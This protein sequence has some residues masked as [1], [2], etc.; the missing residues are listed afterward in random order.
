MDI[1][2]ANLHENIDEAALGKLFE[3]F[4]TVINAVVV[5]DRETGIS[6]G[7]GFVNMQNAIEAQRAID[8]MHGRSVAGKPLTV[9]EANTGN[10]KPEQKK[11][12][13]V[14][15]K[16]TRD[17]SPVISEVDGESYSDDDEPRKKE[18]HKSNYEEK[19]HK[20]TDPSKYEKNL[21]DGYVRISFKK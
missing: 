14:S 12:E 18:Y 8:E 9:R 7:F 19:E 20:L 16:F 10:S 6:K 4:G 17:N 2:V 5:K 13:Y 11:S 3:V 15:V 21:E 1:Y